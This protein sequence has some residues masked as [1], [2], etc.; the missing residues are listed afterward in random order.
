LAL[1]QTLVETERPLPLEK[2][3]TFLHRLSFHLREGGSDFSDAQF[4]IA[5]QRALW[6]LIQLSPGGVLAPRNS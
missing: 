1:A 4:G 5:L 3:S 2:R 6:R